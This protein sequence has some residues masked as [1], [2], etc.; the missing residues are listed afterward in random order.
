MLK[1]PASLTGDLSA[2]KQNTAAV[3]ERKKR[4][5]A[6]HAKGMKA[7][8]RGD[9]QALDEAVKD[10]SRIIQEHVAATKN[11]IPNKAKNAKKKR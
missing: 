11:L 9:M 5:D 7:L 1:T 2:R 8:K 10:E 4:F 3:R 6:A